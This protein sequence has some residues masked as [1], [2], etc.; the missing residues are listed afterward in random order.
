MNEFK[1]DYKTCG[2]ST[3]SN[4]EQSTQWLFRRRNLGDSFNELENWQICF[5]EFLNLC[6]KCLFKLFDV[7]LSIMY[8][9]L[10]DFKAKKDIENCDPIK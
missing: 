4:N 6:K 10:F 5:L 8:I 2:D 1:K 3:H 7:W 9:V